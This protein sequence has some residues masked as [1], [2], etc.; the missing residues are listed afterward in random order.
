MSSSSTEATAAWSGSSRPA[1]QFP[2]GFD[3]P[4]QA[5]RRNPFP[6]YARLREA[7]PLH[8]LGDGWWLLPRYAEINQALRDTA[9]G[10]DIRRWPRPWMVGR[11]DQRLVELMRHMMPFQHGPYHDRLRRLVQLAFTPKAVDAMQPEV[12]KVVDRLLGEVDDRDEFDLVSEVAHRIP[13]TVIATM[14]GV[15]EERR[16]WCS[17]RVIPMARTLDP[18]VSPAEVDSLNAGFEEVE[19]YLLDLVEERRHQPADDLL[20]GMLSAQLDGALLTDTEIVA[21]T[22]ILFLAGQSTTR[23]LITNSVVAVLSH[24]DQAELLREHPELD[25]PAAEEFLR[26]C[27]TIQMIS[28]RVLSDIVI[29]DRQ[30]REDEQLV[31]V[32]A[33]GNRDDRVYERPDALDL[34]RFAHTTPRPPAVLAFGGGTHFCLGANLA[35]METAAVV[36]ELIRRFPDLELAEQD[37]TYP[38]F[39]NRGP[40]RVLLRRTGG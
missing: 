1:I 15:P 31:L 10:N 4:D 40:Q 14:V 30:M 38:G 34:T 21:T 5:F 39:S 33:S 20:S 3:P 2:E 18:D 24:P 17:D 28:K 13:S 25:R 23:S 9:T 35:R 19:V 16:L 32:L 6:V 22:I 26:Y 27:G 8:D 36:P 37:L 11:E 7:A 12:T 29:G